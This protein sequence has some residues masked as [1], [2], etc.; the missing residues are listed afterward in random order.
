MKQEGKSNDLIE[1]IRQSGFF[2]PIHA[3]L[4][5]LL[6]PSTFTGRAA[7]QVDRFTQPNGEV[8]LALKPYRDGPSQA[9]AAAAAATAGGRE[10]VE[11]H[12]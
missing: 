4:D 6:D 3:D 12:V 11:L 5:G 2:E 9:A 1:R 8:D 7:Q 10:K